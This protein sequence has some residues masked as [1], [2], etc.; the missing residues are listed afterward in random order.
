MKKLF[1]ALACVIGLMTFA[2]CDPSA[3]DDLMK[4]KPEIAL[5]PGEGLLTHNTGV[6]VGTE[7]NFQVKVTPNSS[8][9]S[10]IANVEF[11]VKD[12]NGNLLKS[13]NPEFEDPSVENIFDFSFTAENSETTYV[14]TFTVTDQASK[15]NEIVVNVISSEVVEPVNGIY[16]GLVNLHGYI[17]T[18]EIAGHETYNHE[19]KELNDIPV[20]IYYGE[21]NEQGQAHIGI[22]V[23]DTYLSFWCPM[24]GN[25]IHLNK[26]VYYQ[27]VELFVS[28]FVE[29]TANMDCV[30]EDGIMT[31]SGTAEG[32]GEAMVLLAKLEVTLEEGTLEGTLVE[33][34]E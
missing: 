20:N 32:I 14:F 29:I 6:R 7:L 25:T 17:T 13:E 27:S 18:N 33:V 28:V 4:K 10:P 31:L 8:S 12:L 2:S 24:E 15:S 19:E 5:L 26:F 34:T 21:V 11:T 30:V 16:A 9:M 1:F 3:I 23:E 22:E